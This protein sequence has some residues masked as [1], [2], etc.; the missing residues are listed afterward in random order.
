MNDELACFALARHR[1]MKLLADLVVPELAIPHILS[2]AH[3]RLGLGRC[4][5]FDS[6]Q[7]PT[8][9]DLAQWPAPFDL[10]HKCLAF[11]AHSSVSFPARLLLRR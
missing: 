7:C 2:A 11:V 6:A 10:A 8:P 9:F 3:Y 1:L 4:P 5:P